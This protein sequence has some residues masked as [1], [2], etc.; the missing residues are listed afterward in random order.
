MS[1]QGIEIDQS[2]DYDQAKDCV[3]EHASG[4]DTENRIPLS[5]RRSLGL[6]SLRSVLD[7]KPLASNLPTVPANG[8]CQKPH[9]FRKVDATEYTV[10]MT[11]A[12]WLTCTDPIRMVKAARARMRHRKLR[13]FAVACC[14]RIEDL[15]PDPRSRMAIAAAEQHADGAIT[16]MQL[17]EARVAAGAAHSDSFDRL[18]K[19]G[20]C[21][22]WAA[23]FAADRVAFKAAESA[24]WMTHTARKIGEP[25][26]ADYTFQADII[27]DIFGNPFHP[28]SVDPSCLPRDVTALALTIYDERAF[29]RM[30][31]LADALEREGCANVDVLEHCRGPGPH[32]RGCWVVDMLLRR[33]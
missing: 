25:T 27:R 14:H 1:R 22:E 6:A 12:E 18:G 11:E 7:R 31:E 26:P 3:D 17:R 28:V 15:L 23:E 10:D 32:V 2:E 9:A 8:N 21:F 30:P 16:E 20:A 29:D 33:G 13:L 4:D 5:R 24:S 19:V